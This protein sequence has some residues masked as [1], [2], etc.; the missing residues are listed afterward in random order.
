MSSVSLIRRPS[1]LWLAAGLAGL[2]LLDL[3]MATVP[4]SSTVR[5]S[6]RLWA[7]VMWVS[8][9]F[10]VVLSARHARDNTQQHGPDE[11]QLLRLHA[12]SLAA[13]FGPALVHDGNNALL[14]L[15]FQLAELARLHVGD[16][17]AEALVSGLERDLLEMEQLIRRMR[18]LSRIHDEDQIRSLDMVSVLHGIESG[19][20]THLRAQA[21]DLRM[22]L[23]HEILLAAD[24]QRLEQALLGLA[25][26]AVERCGEGG[27][28]LL[29]A[30]VEGSQV[31]VEVHDD[32][33][34]PHPSE[35]EGGQEPFKAGAQNANG[36]QLWASRVCARR[37]RGS[38]ALERS[39]L[40]GLCRRFVMPRDLALDTRPAS[41]RAAVRSDPQ[42]ASAPS[43]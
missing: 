7:S 41:P 23:P 21:C 29:R 11:D 27:N 1:V 28:V 30:H 19:M 10:V 3:V 43:A 16:A 40:G 8:A 33:M 13:A 9:L 25:L 36:L 4:E 12:E 35:F 42:N 6:F 38:L 5:S 37:H 2:V 39:E 24:R 18:A 15:R 26:H 22:E 20:R 14:S 31:T 34:I 17:S 32:G